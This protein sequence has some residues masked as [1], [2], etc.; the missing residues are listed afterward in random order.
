MLRKLPNCHLN[1]VLLKLSTS[2]TSIVYQDL[3]SSYCCNTNTACF[4]VLEHVQ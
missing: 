3:S 2:H 4:I 1:K